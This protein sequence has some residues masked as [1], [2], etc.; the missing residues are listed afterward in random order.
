MPHYIGR[1]FLQLKKLE[2]LF[3]QFFLKVF[4]VQNLLQ[5]VKNKTNCEL[6]SRKKLV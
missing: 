1:F 5:L 2:N 3:T 4:E 6:F